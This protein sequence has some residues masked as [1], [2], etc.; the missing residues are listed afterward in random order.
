MSVART[1]AIEGLLVAL[2]LGAAVFFALVVARA[3]FEVLP[4]RMLAG[5]L[6]GRILPVLFL[7][8][9]VVGVIV[10][11]VEVFA[12]RE[13][14]MRLAAGLTMAGACAAAQFIIGPRIAALRGAIGGP[15]EALAAG[16]PQRAAFGRLHAVSV[17]WLGLAIIAALVALLG[18]WRALDS[19]T[20]LQH[21]ASPTKHTDA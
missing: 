6:V 18:A 1:G 4:T 16:D 21:H 2:W 10:A 3:A 5:A 12:W 15:I 14:S 11:V 20:A 8:G 19:A 9:L 13:R 17:A 7:T